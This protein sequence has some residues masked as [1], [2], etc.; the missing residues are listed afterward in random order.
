MKK[1]TKQILINIAIIIILFS[2]IQVVNYVKDSFT[3]HKTETL[4]EK[5][6]KKIPNEKIKQAKEKNND[7]IGWI[8]M[9]DTNINY[10]IVQT[11]NNEYY[12]NHDLMKNKNQAGWIYMDFRNQ[13]NFS[14]HNTILY[15]HGRID[16]TMFGTLKQL[17]KKD[18]WNTD[19]HSYLITESINKI[20]QWQIFSVYTIKA[21]TYYLNTYFSNQDSYKT[22]L[23]TIKSRSLFS[24]NIPLNTKDQILT[25]STCKNE[26]EDRIVVHAKKIKEESLI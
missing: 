5:Y 4:L 6:N 11:T 2:S 9:N 22:F 16:G 19:S 3:I 14:N 8:K 15:G 20:I 12:L 23:S 24:F 17:L 26:R 1:K 25:L 13:M 7:V 10:P 21:E 18:W